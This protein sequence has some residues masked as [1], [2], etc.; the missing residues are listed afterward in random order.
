MSSRGKR[1]EV[2]REKDVKRRYRDRTLEM[3]GSKE[4]EGYES[5][6]RVESIK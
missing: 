4:L 6:N 2:S 3:E 5:H 1:L